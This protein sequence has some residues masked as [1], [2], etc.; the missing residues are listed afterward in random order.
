MSFCEALLVDDLHQC[1]AG[2]AGGKRPLVLYFL[3]DD[4]FLIKAA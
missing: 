3:G 2:T 1:T 4:L